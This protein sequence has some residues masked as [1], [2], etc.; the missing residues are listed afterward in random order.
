MFAVYVNNSIFAIPVI[1][2]IDTI[3]DLRIPSCNIGNRGSLSDYFGV[4]MTQAPE[5]IILSQ[6]HLVN[7]IVKD[8]GISAK[9]VIS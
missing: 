8:V 9:S 2:Y 5:G 7:Q 3:Y 4:Y 6:P 1:G